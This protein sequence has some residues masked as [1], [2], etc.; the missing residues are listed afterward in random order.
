MKILLAFG[1]RPEIIKLGP[2]YRALRSIGHVPDVFWSGQHVEMAAGLLELFGIRI[3]H[4]GR[5]I[6]TE[7]SLACKFG[8]MIEQ[9][10]RICGARTMPG[11]WSRAIP[12]RRRRQPRRDS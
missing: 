4:T 10:D 7:P 3:T 11:S 5:D 1:T 9:I 2:V 6:M 12:R 8:R